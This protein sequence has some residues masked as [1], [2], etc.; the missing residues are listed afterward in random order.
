[1]PAPENRFFVGVHLDNYNGEGKKAKPEGN[2]QCFFQVVQF[3]YLIHIQRD[4]KTLAEGIALR[5]D[6]AGDYT[7]SASAHHS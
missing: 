3:K 6:F 2:E 4:C 1:M 7:N 5:P